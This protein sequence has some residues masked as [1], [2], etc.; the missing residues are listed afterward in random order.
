M[1]TR[2]LV[3]GSSSRRRSPARCGLEISPRWDGGG[4]VHVIPPLSSRRGMQDVAIA[5]ATPRLS[6]GKG[7]YGAILDPARGAADPVAQRV[8]VDAVG[9]FDRAVAFDHM[10]DPFAAILGAQEHAP[11]VADIAQPLQRSPACRRGC[12][13]MPAFCHILGVAEEI[14]AG[15]LHAAPGAP[16]TRPR[17]AARV[18]RLPWPQARALMSWC[19]FRASIDPAMNRHL[20]ARSVRQSSGRGARSALVDQ[21]A[22]LH[23]PRR[24]KRRVIF[25]ARPRPMGRSVSSALGAGRTAASDQRICSHQRRQRPTAR[26]FTD[27]ALS[28][29][30][31][32]PARC[33]SQTQMDRPVAGECLDLAPELYAKRH[34]VGGVHPDLF[35]SARRKVHQRGGAREQ[36]RSPDCRNC[37]SP[38]KTVLQ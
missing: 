32:Q 36:V 19:S 31:P 18:D 20:V 5:S 15:V 17:S 3:A 30:A 29:S 23:Q 12:P 8:N 9:I 4:V 1:I 22:A 24:R 7:A 16:S 35:S 25:P 21:V 38:V 33:V 6:A 26:P 14:P 37:G 28:G 34:G 10:G 2:S 11:R 27:G 13:S